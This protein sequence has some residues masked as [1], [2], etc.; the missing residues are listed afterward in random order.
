MKIQ[1]STELARMLRFQRFSG[2]TRAALDR[3]SQ[4]VSTGLKADK[5]KATGGNLNRLYSIERMLERV[6]VHERTIDVTETKLDLMQLGLEKAEESA[7]AIAVDMLS[8]VGR[9]ELAS[10]RQHAEASHRAFGQLVEILN[11]NVAGDALFAGT[12]TDG[13]AVLPAA[14]ILAQINGRVAGLSVSD[15]VQAVQDYFAGNGTPNFAADAYLGADDDLAPAEIGD[16]VRVDYAIRATDPRIAEALK[17]HALAALVADGGEF[18]EAADADRLA[19]LGVAGQVLLGAR[20]DLL[21]LRTRT[22]SAQA[23]VESARAERNAEREAYDLARTKIL[24]A[25]AYDAATDLEA[26]KNQLESVF[27]VTAR[28]GSLRFANFLR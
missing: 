17:G 21:A 28:I 10:A 1:G 18:A 5:Y 20:D 22:G 26:M 27:T 16:G 7:A 15:A 23:S 3:A 24:G 6:T 14:D 4:E 8:A 13:P 2:D 19:L 12:A 11:R 9:N 25:D